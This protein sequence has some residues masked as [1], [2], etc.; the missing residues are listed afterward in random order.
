MRLKLDVNLKVAADKI[1]RA[2]IYAVDIPAELINELKRGAPFVS[3]LPDVPTIKASAPPISDTKTVE[4]AATVTKKTVAA[5]KPNA[6]KAKQKVL[7]SAK[8]R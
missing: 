2:G 1:L 5:T 4:P 7:S 6:N 3:E 8:K